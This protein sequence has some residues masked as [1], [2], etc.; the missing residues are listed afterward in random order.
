MILHGPLRFG[1]AAANRT[2][3]R[4]ENGFR[5]PRIAALAAVG[6]NDLSQILLFFFV[7]QE[8]IFLSSH[9]GH[10]FFPFFRFIIS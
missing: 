6:P 9:A 3:S 7:H 8:I 5:H 2:F 10:G 4:S 1:L